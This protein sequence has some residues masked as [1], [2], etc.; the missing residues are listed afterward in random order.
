MLGS[1]LW[2][3]ISPAS[4]RPCPPGSP[5]L[6]YVCSTI[7]RLSPPV[8]PW[9]ALQ[10]KAE[11]RAPGLDSPFFVSQREGEVLQTGGMSSH[12][13]TECPGQIL[14]WQ[15]SVPESLCTTGTI[16]LP[17]LAAEGVEVF[18]K[19]VLGSKVRCVY[20]CSVAGWCLTLC[21]PM[22]CSSPGSSVH[23]ILQEWVA[24]PT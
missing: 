19:G 4:L 17:K 22:D 5:P 13:G 12:V 14:S 16:F 15:A 24:F 3:W 9:P 23:G 21:H 10:V 11:K 20:V 7:S 1:G 18:W 2:G 6:Y 8:G